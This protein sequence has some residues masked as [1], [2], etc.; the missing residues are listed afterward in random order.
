MTVKTGDLYPVWW[1]TDTLEPHMARVM[2]VIPYRGR[3]PQW[4]NAVLILSAPNT[5]RGSLE[6]AVKL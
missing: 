6:M 4:F 3:Y 1:T 2:A 5:K